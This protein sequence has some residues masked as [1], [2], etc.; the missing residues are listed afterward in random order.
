MRLVELSEAQIIVLRGLAAGKKLNAIADDMPPHMRIGEHGITYHM[1]QIYR[2]FSVGS[3]AEAV[4]VA[5]KT[6][7]L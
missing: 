6:G 5:I 4:A 3:R 1:R 2:K 7:L